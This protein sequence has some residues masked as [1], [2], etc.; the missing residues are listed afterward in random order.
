M[1]NLESHFASLEVENGPFA[2]HWNE[3]NLLL[4]VTTNKTD[5]KNQSTEETRC[6]KN[7]STEE[8]Y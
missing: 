4:K 8:C 6:K 2:S 7:E 1:Q 5:E 3:S